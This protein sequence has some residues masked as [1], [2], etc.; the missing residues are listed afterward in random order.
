MGDG[1]GSMH[2]CMNLC[3]RIQKGGRLPYIPTVMDAEH[4]AQRFYHPDSKDYFWAR[5]TYKTEGNFTDHLTGITMPPELWVAGQPNGGLK[6]PCT[7][8][9]GNN[10]KGSLFDVQCTYY[11]MKCQC[12]CQF[13][14]S[15]ILRLRGLCK[16]SMIDTHF[17]MK[18]FNGSVVYKGVKATVIQ[19]IS[20]STIYKWTLN[21]F[22]EKTIAITSAIEMSFI[23]GKQK[24]KVEGD[25]CNESQPYTSQLKMSG[26][27]IKG[28]FTC[29]D[30]QCV[31]MKQRC[32]QIPNCRDKSDEKGCKMLVTEEGYNKEVPPFTVSSTDQTIFPVQLQISIDLLKIVDIKETNHKIDF[33]FKIS[34][35][36]KENNRVV[37]HNLKKDASLNALSKN[38]IGSLWLPLVIYDNTDQKEMTR[39]GEYGNGEWNTPISI[40]REG[41]FTRS[42]LEVLDETEIFEGGENSLF[43]QQVYSWQFQCWNILL[44]PR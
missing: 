35:E 23:L 29:D 44:T 31:T 3:P 4:L 13:D 12:L 25:E 32:D 9:D 39:L 2:D 11:S 7:R 43:M 27:K 41:N 10:P 8:W 17:T 36:W 1:F 20:N 14:R 16:N 30:G 37:Y 15:P 6:Q 21:V 42:G 33:Q 40:I 5:F 24:W 34:L 38:D 18:N 19:Y 22:G 28:E 26:C